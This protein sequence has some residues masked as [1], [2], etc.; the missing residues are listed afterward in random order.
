MNGHRHTM[1]HMTVDDKMLARSIALMEELKDERITIT[2]IREDEKE[3]IGYIY[4][5]L[6]DI[7]KNIVIYDGCVITKEED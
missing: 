5:I 4:G 1:E 2:A 3:V 6:Y 7:R